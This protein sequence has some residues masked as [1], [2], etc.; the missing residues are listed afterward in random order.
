[1]G[2]CFTTIIPF[3]RFSWASSYCKYTP[4]YCKYAS[5]YCIWAPVVNRPQLLRRGHTSDNW[6]PTYNK[7]VLNCH[8]LCI[9]LFDY[10]VKV[11]IY[12]ASINLVPHRGDSV[13]RGDTCITQHLTTLL[14]KCYYLNWIFT[15]L[16]LRPR[17]Y[18]RH[19]PDNIFNQMHFLE[20]CVNFY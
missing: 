13:H 11:H 7:W 4:S 9:Y 5:S 6:G 20:T 17:Q 1:M 15:F 12:F 2:I 8:L 14:I 10:T 18:G 19:F 3:C 16:V